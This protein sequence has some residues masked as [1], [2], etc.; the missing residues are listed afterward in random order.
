MSL[1]RH[2][3][4][5]K[6][7]ATAVTFGPYFRRGRSDT[8][9]LEATLGHLSTSTVQIDWATIDDAR[10]LVGRVTGFLGPNG[11]GSRRR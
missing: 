6:A 9:D 10:P 7:L 8:M 4:Q 1:E 3:I 2:G 5:Q 11:S